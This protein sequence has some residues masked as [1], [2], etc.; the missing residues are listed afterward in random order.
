MSIAVAKGISLIIEKVVEFFTLVPQ[1]L[2]NLAGKDCCR[3]FQP[4]K[5]ANLSQLGVEN[6]QLLQANPW[7]CLAC[8]FPFAVYLVYSGLS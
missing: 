2:T 4:M 1:N 5:M 3:W 6:T 8:C 7:L